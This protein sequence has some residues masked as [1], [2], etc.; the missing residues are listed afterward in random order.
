M[1]VWLNG[2]VFVYKLSGCWFDSSRSV[3]IAFIKNILQEKFLE[4]TIASEIYSYEVN[5]LLF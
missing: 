5:I 3:F 2:W 1:V 4:E